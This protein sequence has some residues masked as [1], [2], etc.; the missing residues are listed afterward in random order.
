METLGKFI[1]I[2]IALFTFVGLGTTLSKANTQ[3][4]GNE[5]DLITA[6]NDAQT[7]DTIELSSDITL[8]KPIEVTGKTLTIIGNGHIVTRVAENWSPNGSNGTL[9]TAGGDGTKLTLANIKLANAQKYGAQTFNGAYLVLDNVNISECGFGGVIVNAGTLEVKDLSLGKN[10]NPS[11]NGIEIAKGSG[12]IGDNKP[13]LIMN[14]KLTSA[15][16]ENVIY[17]AENDNLITFEV[18][19][20]DTTTNKIFVQGKKVVVTDANNTI[21][22]E[23]NE[24]SNIQVTGTEYTE[25][26]QPDINDIEKDETPKPTDPPKEEERTNPKTGVENYL[27]FAIISLF[28][29]ISGI[30]YFNKKAY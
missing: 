29:T 1:L 4:V 25:N 21:I 30:A 10:G 7:G 12:V 11:N 23:S 2:T 14:G 17:L 16:N 18:R 24:N 26:T 13:V 19:N 6:V 20:T 28:A 15:Q 22:F 8:T 9:I 27:G 3:T 5:Q